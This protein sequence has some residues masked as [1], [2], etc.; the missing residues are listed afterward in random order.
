MQALVLNPFQATLS[1]FPVGLSINPRGYRLRCEE[2]FRVLLVVSCE[3]TVVQARLGLFILQAHESPNHSR[4]I[5]LK[6]GKCH[7]VHKRGVV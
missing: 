2:F 6:R 1:I 3:M 4:L 5:L 7:D